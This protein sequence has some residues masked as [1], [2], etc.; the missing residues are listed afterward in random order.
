[1]LLEVDD[2]C[3]N[4]GHIEAIRNISFTVGE[5]E[6]VVGDVVLVRP[7]AKIPVDGVVVQGESEVDESMVTGE[8]LPVAKL[9]GSEVIGASVNTTGTLRVRASKVGSDTALAQ[10]VAMVQEAQGLFPKADLVVSDT[11]SHLLDPALHALLKERL[12]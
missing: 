3:V 2:L 11:S 5:G 10:I 7:G 4:Y 9:E 6:V 1:M 12:S 8:S